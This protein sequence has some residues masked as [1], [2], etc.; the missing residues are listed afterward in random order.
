MHYK[1]AIKLLQDKFGHSEEAWTRAIYTYFTMTKSDELWRE[2]DVEQLLEDDHNGYFYYC[3]DLMSFNE[4][5][6][7]YGFSVVER[8]IEEFEEVYKRHEKYLSMDKNFYFS[9]KPIDAD[10]QALIITRSKF[11]DPTTPK[12]LYYLFYMY[13]FINITKGEKVIYELV[14]NNAKLCKEEPEYNYY[15]VPEEFLETFLM[16]LDKNILS[17][18][19]ADFISFM[20]YKHDIGDTETA[21]MRVPV[22]YAD[23]VSV[24]PLSD[25][26]ELVEEDGVDKFDFTHYYSWEYGSFI[27]YDPTLGFPDLMMDKE[28]YLDIKKECKKF[29]IL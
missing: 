15:Y 18:T 7:K 28:E 9:F 2:S 20:N 5:L 29:C 27:I 25:F 12:R 11:F 24:I 23:L 6:N 10:S 8:P 13:N 16:A 26:V 21:R 1:E 4:E 19:Y 17:L 3:K 22:D 14:D